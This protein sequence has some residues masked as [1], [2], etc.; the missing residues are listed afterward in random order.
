MLFVLWLLY[1]VSF[2]ERYIVTMLVDPMKRDLGLSDLQMGLILGPAFAVCYAAATI[3]FGWLADRFSRRSVIFGGVTIWSIA[4]MGVGLARSFGAL[5][6]V[7]IG[8]GLGE[9]ALTPTAYSLVSDGFPRERLTI[10]FAI[11]QTGVKFG[12]AAAFIVGGALLTYANSLGDIS[13]GGFKLF[14]WQFVMLVAGAPGIVIAWLV[15]T[16]REPARVTP[17]AVSADGLVPFLKSHRRLMTLMGLGF[18]FM[19]VCPS[20]LSMWVPSF[21][22]RNYGWSPV[23]YGT[24]LGLINIL[25]A[26][27]VVFKGGLVDWLFARGMADAHIR[28]YCWLLVIGIPIAC[29]AFF[30][31]DARLFLALYGV[32]QVIVIPYSFY[33]NATLSIVVPSHFRGR[34]FGTMLLMFSLVGGAIGP[35]IVG[36]LT[37]RVFGGPANVGISLA[38]TLGFCMPAAL[39]CL[40][41]VLG[42]VRC[43][44]NEVD[45]AIQQELEVRMLGPLQERNVT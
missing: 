31:P 28:F 8:V 33:A 4:T 25:A 21:I 23:Q 29:G 36:F 10:A 45:L 16:F 44:V 17:I 1:S 18:T 9:A 40:V 2:L 30:V 14:P 19:S 26:V 27:T 34:I 22:L 3:P 15:F 13:F 37:D 6:G 20:A 11:F 32:L 7:R 24:A 43:A 41:R 12:S 38:V 39:I 5:F 42:E 35:V